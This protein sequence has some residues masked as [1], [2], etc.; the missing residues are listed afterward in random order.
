MDGFCRVTDSLVTNWR[1]MKIPVFVDC[2]NFEDTVRQATCLLL[3]TSLP[4]LGGRP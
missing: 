3:F 4:H 2:R 1:V